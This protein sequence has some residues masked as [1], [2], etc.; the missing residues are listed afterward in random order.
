MFSQTTHFRKLTMT[1]RL[2]TERLDCITLVVEGRY[3]KDS[4]G[5]GWF[6]LVGVYKHIE[7]ICK[8]Q[9]IEVVFIV[10]ETQTLYESYLVA[11]AK[12]K[13]ECHATSTLR[14]QENMSTALHNIE[15]T[16]VILVS[17]ED[18]WR[19]KMEMLRSDGVEV[20]VCDSTSY[21][22]TVNGRVVSLD[23]ILDKAGKLPRSSHDI[24]R[25]HQIAYVEEDAEGFVDVLASVLE[26]GADKHVLRYVVHV[27]WNLHWFDAI[28][29]LIPHLDQDMLDRML[30]LCSQGYPSTLLPPD[31]SELEAMKM[32][33]E[34][35]AN[36][37]AFQN[38]PLQQAYFVEICGERLGYDLNKMEF[39]LEK[40]ADSEVIV[41]DVME[42]GYAEVIDLLERFGVRLSCIKAG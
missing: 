21:P 38:K 35:G 25:L 16:Q 3:F 30:V 37:C 2:V 12:T 27:I 32:L 13:I 36:V 6:D 11:E 40:G 17:H 8:K 28:Q 5:F 26:C 29:V 9:V 34:A 31:T 33:V 41:L 1:T 24:A 4:R 10:D 42:Q 14:L 22:L 18:E 20:F 7:K 15:S 19:N 23:E 39:L